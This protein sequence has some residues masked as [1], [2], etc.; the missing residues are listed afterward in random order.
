MQKVVFFNG[1]PFSGKDTALRLLPS[2]KRVSFADVLKDQF[3]AAFSYYERPEGADK[4]LP[5]PEP[6]QAQTYRQGL[7]GYSERFMK[8]LFGQDIFGKILLEEMRH[9]RHPVFGITDSGFEY[10]AQPIIDHYGIGNCALVRVVR[11]GYDFK[12]DS[13]TYWKTTF[14]MKQFVAYNTGSLEDYRS[15]LQPILQWAFPND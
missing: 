11:T 5:M 4:D 12:G 10:E 8:P 15:I 13:R 3:E 1:P 6:F 2:L 7:I 9:D 14:Q